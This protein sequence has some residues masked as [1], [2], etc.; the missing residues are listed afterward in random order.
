MIPHPIVNRYYEIAQSWGVGVDDK[1]M[2]TEKVVFAVVMSMYDA[3]NDYRLYNCDASFVR[4]IFC[5]FGFVVCWLSVI[6]S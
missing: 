1:M 5:R 4:F 6:E 3:D 2:R